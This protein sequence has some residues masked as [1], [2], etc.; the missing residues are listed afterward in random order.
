[1]GFPFNRE[2]AFKKN[3]LLIFGIFLLSGLNTFFFRILWKMYA[4]FHLGQ[5]PSWLY[6]LSRGYWLI[7]YVPSSHFPFLADFFPRWS[8]PNLAFQVWQWYIHCH[9][10]YS[11][12]LAAAHPLL[13]CP[14]TFPSNRARFS[15]NMYKSRSHYKLWNIKLKYACQLMQNDIKVRWIQLRY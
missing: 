3:N 13:F 5:N 14:S 11:T 1:M 12:H 4:L 8:V 2:N 10:N 7:D 15:Y 6:K 9:C